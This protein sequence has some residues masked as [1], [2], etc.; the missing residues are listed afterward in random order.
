MRYS[1]KLGCLIYQDEVLGEQSLCEPT[2]LFLLG[3]ESILYPERVDSRFLYFSRESISDLF[4]SVYEYLYNKPS[5]SSITYIEYDCSGAKLFINDLTGKDVDK[6][7]PIIFHDDRYES[8]LKFG[9]DTTYDEKAQKIIYLFEDAGYNKS[10]GTVKVISK[11]GITDPDIIAQIDAKN[12]EYLEIHKRKVLNSQIYKL[13]DYK[14]MYSFALGVLYGCQCIGYNE[15]F[16]YRIE[17]SMW[18]DDDYVNLVTTAFYTFKFHY[19]SQIPEID[20]DIKLSCKYKGIQFNKLW[21]FDNDKFNIKQDEILCYSTYTENGNLVT[22]PIMYSQ[23][24]GP[25]EPV[26]GSYMLIGEDTVWRSLDNT[27]LDSESGKGIIAADEETIVLNIDGT[28]VEARV[29]YCCDD[30][31]YLSP[32]LK[33]EYFIYTDNIG[34]KSL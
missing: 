15:D 12:E 3:L 29:A 21:N 5:D 25:K 7:M 8:V 23:H 1:S 27:V 11:S 28:T 4:D 22:T 33:K 18:Y 14:S 6:V 2:M 20:S 19:T 26:P 31:L 10:A 16:I 34:W 17:P 13:L 9:P 24:T 30:K 32:N